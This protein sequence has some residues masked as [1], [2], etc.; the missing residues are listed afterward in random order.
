MIPRLL[1]FAGRANACRGTLHVPE[2]SSRTRSQAQISSLKQ[3]LNRRRPGTDIR[4]GNQ[5]AYAI[6]P[7]SKSVI[8]IPV[9][10]T[11]CF[12]TLKER[13]GGTCTYGT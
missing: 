5:R 6:C 9:G 10:A 7:Y 4:P 8:A 13:A 2:C 12:L 3:L 1:S 11:G